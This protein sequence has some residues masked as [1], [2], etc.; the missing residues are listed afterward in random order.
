MPATLTSFAKRSTE[1]SA[2]KHAVGQ[3]DCLRIGDWSPML[4]SVPDDKAVRVRYALRT[5]PPATGGVG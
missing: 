5:Q 4:F 3:E 1:P 2:S